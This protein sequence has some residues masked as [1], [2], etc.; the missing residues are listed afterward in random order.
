LEGR[1]LATRHIQDDDYLPLE[2]EEIGS[3]TNHISPQSRYFVS[4]TTIPN[5]GTFGR[6]C[7][8]IYVLEKVQFAVQDTDF[9]QEKLMRLGRELQ[10]LLSTV[11]GQT[12]GR[13]GYYSGA[14]K[15][16]IMY[17]I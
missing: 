5:V 6:E 15:C 9:N 7:Q 4:A 8:A 1:P 13:W 12:A 14:T 3:D 17:V 10:S 16:L 11:M 2:A